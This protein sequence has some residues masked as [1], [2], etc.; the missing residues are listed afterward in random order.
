M[1]VCSL[2]LGGMRWEHW[3]S[4][5]C[6]PQRWQLHWW[7]SHWELSSSVSGHTF[8]VMTPS[9]PPGWWW[10]E[11]WKREIIAVRICWVI[12]ETQT[13]SGNISSFSHVSSWDCTFSKMPCSINNIVCLNMPFWAPVVQT[14]LDHSG[15][16]KE[17]PRG[18]PRKGDTK[19]ETKCNYKWQG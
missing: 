7:Q 9:N 13:I 10:W 17:A 6:H 14:C 5:S 3:D 15:G 19:G 12:N 2:A 1:V 4:D 8:I 16:L 18:T 11:K